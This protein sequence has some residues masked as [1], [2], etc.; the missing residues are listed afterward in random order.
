MTF[1]YL[2]KLQANIWG[3]RRL[4]ECRHLI[5]CICIHYCASHKDFLHIM[6]NWKKNYPD[7]DY[8]EIPVSCVKKIY[9]DVDWDRI[10]VRDWTLQWP[11]KK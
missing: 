5:E 7:A 10:P 1:F 2:R 11:E 8:I 4:I 3:S 9:G 6:D